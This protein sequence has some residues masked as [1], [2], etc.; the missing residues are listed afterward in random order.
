MSIGVV[1]KKPEMKKNIGKS[2]SDKRNFIKVN[3]KILERINL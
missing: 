1:E 2:I 3:L